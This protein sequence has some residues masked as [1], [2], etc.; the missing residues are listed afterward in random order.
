[1]LRSL[2]VLVLAALGLWLT[3][4]SVLVVA[5]RRRGSLRDGAR[6]LPDTLVLVRRLAGDRSIPRSARWPLWGLLVYLAVPIDLVPD[7][8]PVIGW[9]DDV[10]LASLV[11]GHLLRRAGPGTLARHW[12]GTDEGLAVLM[13]V[14]RLRTDGPA[15][16]GTAR[17]GAPR[18][19]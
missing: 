1:V 16:E 2:V 7:F 13:Q 9:A 15:V 18:G 19:A 17:D 3:L 6:V 4:L 10:I 12:P 14:L 5:G 11:V 8:I